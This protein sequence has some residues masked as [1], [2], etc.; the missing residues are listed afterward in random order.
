MQKSEDTGTGGFTSLNDPKSVA[1]LENGL[2][3]YVTA[4]HP[5]IDTEKSQPIG[6]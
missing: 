1:R 6:C 4:V 3:G 5:R 2:L